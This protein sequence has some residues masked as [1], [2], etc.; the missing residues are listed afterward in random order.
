M[1]NLGVVADSGLT[2][3]NSSESTLMANVPIGLFG[4]VFLVI[5]AGFI[6]WLMYMRRE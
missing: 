2:R 4:I 1:V 3:V 6:I 5:L